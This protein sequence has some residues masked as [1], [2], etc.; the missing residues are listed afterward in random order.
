[1]E[2]EEFRGDL[3]DLTAQDAPAPRGLVLLDLKTA[4]PEEIH[5]QVD[6]HGFAFF[7]ASKRKLS[8]LIQRLAELRDQFFASDEAYK[9]KYIT[10]TFGDTGYCER[11]DLKEQFQVRLGGGTLPAPAIGSLASLALPC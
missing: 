7:K 8:K 9:L 1:M 5:Y 10:N 6:H 3:F 11:T 4:L 2:P